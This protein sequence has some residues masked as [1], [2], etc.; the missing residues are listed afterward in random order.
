MQSKLVGWKSQTLNFAGRLTLVQAVTAS[1]PIYTMQTTKLPNSVCSTCDKMNRDFLWGSCDS[2]K[3]IY[4]VSWP[5][6]CRPNV[7]GGLGLKRFVQMNQAKLAKISWQIFQ[8]DKG[9]WSKVV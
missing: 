1:I 8:N 4:L 3:K 9:L 2:G 5:M 6:V 7:N